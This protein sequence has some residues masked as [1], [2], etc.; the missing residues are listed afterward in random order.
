MTRLQHTSRLWFTAALLA[1]LFLFC[2]PGAW[3]TAVPPSDATLTFALTEVPED[4]RL[5]VTVSLRNSDTG[6]DYDITAH[7]VGDYTNTAMVKTGHYEVTGA[8]IH[9]YEGVG[10]MLTLDQTSFDMTGD[11]TLTGRLTLGSASQEQDGYDGEEGALTVGGQPLTGD[12]ELVDPGDGPDEELVPELTVEPDSG[13]E[14]EAGES[15][16]PEPEPEPEPEA[17]TE[18]ETEP[19]T[20]PA[21]SLEGVL[22]TVA[23]VLVVLAVTLGLSWVVVTLRNR[24]TRL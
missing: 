13:P 3:A 20:E 5:D 16:D 7:Y 17:P 2:I 21:G 18:E 1:A 15:P 10:Y 24:A 6:E 23:L 19:D 4:Y 8:D 22:G 12:T 11:M 14:G 9:D